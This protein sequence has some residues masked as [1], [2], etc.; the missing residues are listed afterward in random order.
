MNSDTA[1]KQSFGEAEPALVWCKRHVMSG[2]MDAAAPGFGNQDGHLASVQCHLELNGS[3]H[4]D[5][6]ESQWTDAISCASD[7]MGAAI[8]KGGNC[9]SAHIV[10]Q[11]SDTASCHDKVPP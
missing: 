6:L 3:M 5:V 10:L 7:T 1:L 11:A 4:V 9:L 2:T 8:V